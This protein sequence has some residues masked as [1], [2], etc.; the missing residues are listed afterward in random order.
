MIVSEM[1]NFNKKLGNILQKKR[2]E[3]E[4]LKQKKEEELKSNRGTSTVN[5]NNDNGSDDDD[6]KIIPKKKLSAMSLPTKIIGPGIDMSSDK[7]VANMA[8]GFLRKANEIAGQ[9]T[10]INEDDQKAVIANA[11]CDLQDAIGG[12]RVEK[13]VVFNA[14]RAAFTS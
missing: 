3:E 8:R 5:N 14:T 1:S 6:C 12:G 11:W 2:K 7:V 9:Y 10:G 13:T 4:Q